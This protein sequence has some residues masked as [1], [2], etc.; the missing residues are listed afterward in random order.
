M[1]AAVLPARR[2]D[3]TEGEAAHSEYRYLVGRVDVV[4][5]LGVG[6]QDVRVEFPAA[7]E[8]GITLKNIVVA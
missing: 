2:A 1:R 4:V 5:S 7:H 3:R 6:S 8:L